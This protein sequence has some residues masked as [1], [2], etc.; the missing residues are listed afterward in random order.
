MIGPHCNIGLSVCG[1]LW[2]FNDGGD[3]LETPCSD[4]MLYGYKNCGHLRTLMMVCAH[5]ITLLVNSRYTG[6]ELVLL[7]VCVRTALVSV[8]YIGE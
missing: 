8:V 2:N 3:E 6:L 1:P 7:C 5:K 4:C